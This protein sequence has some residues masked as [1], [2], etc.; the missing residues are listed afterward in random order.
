MPAHELQLK[1][2]SW[3]HAPGVSFFGTGDVGP[4][5]L[6]VVLDSSQLGT[7]VTSALASLFSGCKLA[8]Q[9]LQVCWNFQC[10]VWRSFD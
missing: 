2:L 7:F 4:P 3:R 5:Y 6:E 1:G 10:I 8:S 9:A